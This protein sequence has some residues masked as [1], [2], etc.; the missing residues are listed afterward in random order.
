MPANGPGC[1]EGSREE[2]AMAHLASGET[3]WC[4]QE[5]MDSGGHGH[6]LDQPG[7]LRQVLQ[8]PRMG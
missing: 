6:E 1:W 3:A 7:H 5:S 4:C 2:G 8:L